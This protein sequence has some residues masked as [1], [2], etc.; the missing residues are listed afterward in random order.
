MP[1]YPF[2]T[3]I[4]Y[5]RTPMITK[6]ITVRA[7]V[8]YV[9]LTPIR[10]PSER[11]AYYRV[12]VIIPMSDTET[13]RRLRESVRAADETCTLPEVLKI[14]D[15][16]GIPPYTGAYYFTAK[17]STDLS[18]PRITGTPREGASVSITLRAMQTYRLGE[19]TVSFRLES[20]DF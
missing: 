10:R 7:V 17:R 13:L 5:A 4:F 3:P 9:H 2:L 12:D 18:A 19:R 8:N 1:F 20:I 16:K 14:G 15:L 6:R 11:K